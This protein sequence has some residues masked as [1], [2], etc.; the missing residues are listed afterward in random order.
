MTKPHKSLVGTIYCTIKEIKL[1]FLIREQT[2][3]LNGKMHALVIQHM[4][5]LWTTLYVS[6]TTQADCYKI[7]T[8]A[9]HMTE[10]HAH[11]SGLELG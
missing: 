8:W 6:N 2:Q 11:N 4:C 10:T 9:P 1:V 7:K 5:Y 3:E